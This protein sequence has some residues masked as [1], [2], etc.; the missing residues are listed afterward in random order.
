MK[1]VIIS[2]FAATVFVFS[3]YSVYSQKSKTGLTPWVSEKGYWVVEGNIH[4]PLTHIIRFYNNDNL[5]LHTEKLSGVKLNINK[6]NVKMKLKNA[7]EQTVLLSDEHKKEGVI[8]DYITS[9]LK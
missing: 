7:L 9:I 2:V 5:L 6:K 1:Q 3:T 8:S 4:D